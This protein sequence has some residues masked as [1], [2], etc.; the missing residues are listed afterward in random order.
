MQETILENSRGSSIQGIECAAL[1]FRKVKPKERSS[2]KEHRVNALALGADE[3]RSDLRKAMVS[4]K[5]AMTH[6][7]PNGGTHL[8]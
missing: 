8:G 2:Y 1:R 4:R 6:G 7:F 5:Q 3:G